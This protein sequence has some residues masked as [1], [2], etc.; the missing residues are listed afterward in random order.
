MK[1]KV[2]MEQLKQSSKRIEAY[3]IEY[4]KTYQRLYQQVDNLNGWQGGDKQAFV[5]QI[6]GFKNDY[7]KM[8]DVL[9]QYHNFL[10]KSASA[11]QKLLED[12]RNQARKLTR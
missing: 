12:R 5:E 3:V 8:K 9:V 6:H 11:Y 2:D 10:R 1:I 7:V 4:E